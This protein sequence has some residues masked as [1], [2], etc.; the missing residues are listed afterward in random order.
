MDNAASGARKRAKPW[1]AQARHDLAAA[2]ANAGDGRHALACF[3]CHQSAEKAVTGF[4][5]SR[6]A[7]Q[8]WGHALADLCEDALAFDQSF[9][10]VKS[11]AVLLDK[12]F[13]G[14]RYPESIV[15][16]VPAEAY[17]QDDSERALEIAGDVL[18]AVEQ[19]MDG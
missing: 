3:L 2:Q 15:G 8:V 7:E 9:D 18:E 1:L 4:L 5:Y 13:L 17:E 14:A 19:R 16:G 6:G 12:H 11:I 10:L